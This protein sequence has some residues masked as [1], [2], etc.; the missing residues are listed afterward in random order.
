MD[1]SPIAPAWFVLPLASVALLLQAGY[2]VALRELPCD[3]MPPSRKRIRVATGWL[4]MF[5]I[6]LSAYGF[7][8]ATPAD[9]GTFTLVWLAVIGL[10]AGIL[11]LAMLDTVNT[12][13]L[14][15]HAR[16]DLHRELRTHL[17]RDLDEMLQR[18]RDGGAQ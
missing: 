2:L 16:R 3:R 5:A 18:R 15:R 13:R 4:S 8:I 7:G 14:H 11:L 1:P 10:I 12:M 17:R 9:P 6:P